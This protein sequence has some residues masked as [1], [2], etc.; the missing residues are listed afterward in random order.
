MIRL[1]KVGR[2]GLFQG[3]VPDKLEAA[4]WNKLSYEKKG[5]EWMPNRLWGIVRFY[6]KKR[7]KF[8]WG[9]ADQVEKILQQW[10]EQYDEPYEIVDDTKIETIDGAKCY[11]EIEGLRPYQVD[12]V[13]SLIINQGGVCAIPTGGGKTR[14]VLKFFSKVKY[15]R[16]LV[17]VTTLDLFNQWRDVVGEMGLANV[18][19][20]T[21][22]SLHAEQYKPAKL[23]QYSFVV[24]D[25]S[26][27]VAAHS[28]YAI[29]LH[30]TNAILI[31]LSATPH[32]ADGEDMRIKAVMGNIVYK[33]SIRE[34]IKMG[35]LVDAEIKIID[36]LGACK[37][38]PWD[39]YPEV[40]QQFIVENEER[41]Q[42]IIRAAEASVETGVVLILVEKREHG[43]YFEKAFAQMNKYHHIFVHGDSKKRKIIFDDV[44]AGRYQIVIATKIYGEGVDIP[45]L[46][47]LILANGGMSA[48]KIVQEIGRMLR[49]CAGKDKAIIYD[50]SDT[51]KYL[52]NHYKERMSTYM[53]HEFKIDTA[54]I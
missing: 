22:Q 14:T 33:I 45:I 25:E 47:T 11:A 6:Q 36:L 43:V 29:A 46:K 27:H 20:K 10:Q 30:C 28:L 39:T 1:K 15:G 12:A 7:Q 4:L 9:L 16:A 51:A 23:D 40:Y 21:Y 54:E 53:L 49:N 24:F 48:V 35:Y 34:L 8:P 52:S 2:W 44:K 26:H 37:V 32:R 41:N 38:Q 3:K 50:F 13:N 5:I 31:G 17:I 19:V 42:K 18:D